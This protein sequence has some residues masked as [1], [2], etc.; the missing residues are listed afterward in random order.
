[1]GKTAKALWRKVLWE[2]QPYPDNYVPST[3][4]SQLVKNG[5][6]LLS[7]CHAFC[8]TR[9]DWSEH[10]I[11][12]DLFSVMEDS[13][14]ISQQMSFTLLFVCCFIFSF[15]GHLSPTDLRL[16][17]FASFGFGVLLYT[18]TTRTFDA[19]KFHRMLSIVRLMAVVMFL[20]PVLHNLCRDISDDTVWA[21]TTLLLCAHLFTCDYAYV[22]AY[23]E[24]YAA[25]HAYASRTLA[26][27]RAYVPG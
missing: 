18:L 11:E 8:C 9:A 7:F 26:C 22:N 5:E 23:S 13:L 20:S 24:S 21:C 1:M 25:L 10:F 27:W 4:L 3:F 17:C 12:Y 14:V 19:L 16:I 6:I 2:R 15:D